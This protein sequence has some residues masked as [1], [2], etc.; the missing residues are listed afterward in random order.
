MSRQNKKKNFI[1]RETS[2]E[3]NEKSLSKILKSKNKKRV[4]LNLFD[5]RELSREENLDVVL[6]GAFKTKSR[7]KKSDMILVQLKVYLRFFDQ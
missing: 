4:E 2:R 5:I 1:Y 7:K 3:Q 6:Y